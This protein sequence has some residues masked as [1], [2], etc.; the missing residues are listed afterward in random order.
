MKIDINCDMGESYGRFKIGND[1]TIFPY[2]TSCNIACGFHGGDPLTI[3][4]TI[5]KAI[6]YGVRI[7]GHPSFPDLSG[8]G[9]RY[10]EMRGEEL[11]ALVKY[12]IGALKSMTESEGGELSYVKPHGALY[13]M[14]A[15]NISVA[16]CI[17]QAISEIDNN[18]KLMGMAGSEMEE[19]AKKNK[20]KF[21]AEAFADRRYE[22]DGE[23]MSR[24]KEGAVISDA[25]EAAEQMLSMVKNK[26]VETS[27]G[28]LILIHAQSFCI[29]GD[30][31]NAVNIL[32]KINEKLNQYG[33]E[34]GH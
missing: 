11:K 15:K 28:G 12:Q 20:L 31:P 8:F 9:R 30:N 26:S 24:N 10:M 33:I 19:A 25:E 3:E 22:P 32:K 34:K 27:S 1:D 4:N 2:I 13:N 29:H 23:L 17:G 7:G 6:K 18:L 5:K 14:A 16:M 21:V